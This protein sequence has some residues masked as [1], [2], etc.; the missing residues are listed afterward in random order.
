MSQAGSS[1][2]HTSSVLTSPSLLLTC[3]SSRSQV[4][5][6]KRRTT[7]SGT[8]K[9]KSKDTEGP[10]LWEL[11]YKTI[12]ECAGKG[13]LHH[14]LF[15]KR[16]QHIPEGHPSLCL[17]TLG[18]MLAAHSSTTSRIPAGALS[19]SQEY[20]LPCVSPASLPATHLCVLRGSAREASFQH[21]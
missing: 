1:C 6:T 19:A 16:P 12:L 13:L 8:Q 14:S 15:L 10:L 21:P 9:I 18:L 4:Q 2:L 17:A 3:E 7:S 11:L 5:P 20:A